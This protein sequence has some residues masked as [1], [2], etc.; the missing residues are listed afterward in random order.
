MANQDSSSCYSKSSHDENEWTMPE[1]DENRKWLVHKIHISPDQEVD[2]DQLMLS[3]R[4]EDAATDIRVL[5]HRSGHVQKVLVKEGDSISSGENILFVLELKLGTEKSPEPENKGRFSDEAMLTIHNEPYLK[6][7]AR[8]PE[9]ENA[10]TVNIWLAL[11]ESGNPIKIGDGTYGMVLQAY[12]HGNNYAI[13]ILH[14]RDY[15]AGEATTVNLPIDKS[16]IYASLGMRSAKERFEAEASA[17]YEIKLKL[18]ETNPAATANTIVDLAGWTEEFPIHCFKDFWD[19]QGLRPSKYAL[20]TH[21]YEGTLKDLLEEK[22][23]QQT[24]KTGYD[25]LRGLTY[26]ERMAAILPFVEGIASGL[27]LMHEAHYVHLDIKPANVFWRKEGNNTNLGVAIGDLGY[28]RET[29]KTVEIA[30]DADAALG[31]LR[32]R[33]PEQKNFK[34]GCEVRVESGDD[35]NARLIT[36]DPKFQDTI[37]EKSYDQK[38]WMRGE[39]AY[40]G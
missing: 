29:T 14:D 10:S 25:I 39:A 34:D 13:K 21:L 16:L 22:N 5:A 8:G 26:P 2:R 23:K 36:R 20:V 17:L 24:G 27:Q 18:H 38:L 1:L 11:D 35:G 19:K 31:T 28:I 15:A 32:Y 7:S 12:D 37:M 9:E 4:G 40:P 3:I 33:S 6:G 30:C